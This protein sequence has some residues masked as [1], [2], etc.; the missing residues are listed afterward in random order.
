MAYER[1][2]ARMTL[3]GTDVDDTFPERHTLDSPPELRSQPDALDEDGPV[4]NTTRPFRRRSRRRSESIEGYEMRDRY[5]EAM[6]IID[7]DLKGAAKA[8]AVW[9]YVYD[10][11]CLPPSGGIKTPV[12]HRLG[13]LPIRRAWRR[14]NS[15]ERP[16]LGST[17]NVEAVML[18]ERGMM[19]SQQSQCTHC[20]RG[21]GISPGCVVMEPGDEIQETSDS[22]GELSSTCSNCH[23]DARD[24]QCDVRIPSSGPKLP[25]R[26]QTPSQI[27]K[28]FAS[29][30]VHLEVLDL[31]DKALK[32]RSGDGKD[33]VVA[34]AKQIETAALEIAQAAHEWGQSIKEKHQ[35]NIDS[36]EHTS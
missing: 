10:P 13:N 23:Y 4:Y 18:Y 11:V 35:R 32:V 25:S 29:N 26:T 12:I 36:T 28:S 20:Q 9:D 14:R 16:D 6:D 31:V 33:D 8:P 21:R 19:L 22:I 5:W 2:I 1:Y 24:S 3:R 15:R 27:K 17:R 7:R 30:P 34:R